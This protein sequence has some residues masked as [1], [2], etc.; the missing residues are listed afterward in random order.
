LV[1][2]IVTT[3]SPS[4]HVAAVPLATTSPFTAMKMVAALSMGVAVMVLVAFV[5]SA[6]YSVIPLSKAG[7]RLSEPIVS[8]DRP[9]FKG[10]S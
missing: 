10:L 3:F 5:V 9:A 7:I 4:D 2:V 1:T 6:V 8:P